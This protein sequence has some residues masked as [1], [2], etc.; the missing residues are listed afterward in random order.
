[1]GCGLVRGGEKRVVPAPNNEG[2]I[3][4]AGKLTKKSQGVLTVPGR[5][6]AS[7]GPAKG[8]GQIQ[9]REYEHRRN[10]RANCCTPRG[11]GNWSKRGDGSRGL[12]GVSH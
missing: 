9:Q 4:G 1:V 5:R 6:Q 7:S 12:G 11:R 2:T 8:G 3:V 10:M